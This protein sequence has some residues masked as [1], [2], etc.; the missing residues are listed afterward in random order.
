M[1][2]SAIKDPIKLALSDRSR[3]WN[4]INGSRMGS[5][6]GAILGPSL[7]LLPGGRQIAQFHMAC[8][9]GRTWPLC[10]AVER[11]ALNVSGGTTSV[12][13]SG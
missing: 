6:K 3:G 10:H 9:V 2:E 8:D 5:R 12:A 13:A 4:V 11:F 7:V 1:S